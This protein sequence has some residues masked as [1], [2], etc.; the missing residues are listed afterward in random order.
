MKR[1]R[2]HGRNILVVSLGCP[3]NLVDAEVMCGQLAT[4]GFVLTNDP[5]AAD[6][7]LINT[8]GF[9]NDA[10]SEAH[11]EIEKSLRWKKRQRGR[12]VVVGGCLPQRNLAEVKAAY[13]EV[14]LFL[15]LNDVPRVAEALRA[16]SGAVVP[17]QHSL[18]EA[19][20]LYDHSTPRLQLTPHHYAYL[21]IAEGCDHRCRFCSIPAIRGAQ[22]SRTLDSVV[23]EARGLIDQGTKELN[24]IA[25][26]TT[27]YGVDLKNGTGIVDLLKAC[28]A[29]DGNFWIRLIYAHPR[30]LQPELLELMAASRHIVPYIDIPLQHISDSVLQR[31]GRGI[32]SAATKKLMRDIRERIP[33]VTVR[34]T[35]IVGYPGET[36]A[37]FDELC[38]YVKAYRFER[39]GV[40]TYSPEEGTA[41]SRLTDTPVSREVADRRRHR[42]LELQQT[43]A[44][45]KNQAL[46]GREMTVLADYLE[47]R[48]RIAGRTAGDAPD[49]DNLV[50]F[51]GTAADFE[52][53]FSR[54]RITG[55]SEYDLE[56]VIVP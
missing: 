16:L 45:E 43:I 4:E 33:G 38:E 17:D 50:H 36:E 22:R 56:G 53:G 42:L 13:P 20:Y 46:V 1:S 55:A 10:R 54:V 9:I 49:I 48:G 44:L 47:T 39:M 2:S 30:Y 28:D 29:L 18:G 7:T 24:L 27:R 32:G 15:G 23:Q 52:R 6:I 41:A 25:Q 34:T 26:D 12:R 19:V 51:S 31:M 8:C 5:E 11:E 3:K 40:F 21:K 35:F 37:D 14:D